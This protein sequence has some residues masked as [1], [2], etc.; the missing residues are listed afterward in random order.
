MNQALVGLRDVDDVLGSFVIGARGE[1]LAKD[2]PQVF[3]DELFAEMGPR[4]VRLRETLEAGGEGMGSLLLRFDEHKL[5]VRAVG[6]SLL[7]VVTG[8]KVNAPALRMAT[9]LV[10]RRIES[11]AN[12]PGRLE[13]PSVRPSVPEVSPHASAPPRDSAPPTRKDVLY[14]GRLR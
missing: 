9:N 14:R 4:L 10:V 11:E 12:N 2:L 1:L 7:G 13:P 5:H 3:R 6:A 8:A